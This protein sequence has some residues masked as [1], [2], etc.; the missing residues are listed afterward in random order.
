MV[1]ASASR[2]LRFLPL[3]SALLLTA[4]CQTYSSEAVR[5]RNS[6]LEIIASEID[7]IATELRPHFDGDSK[8][9]H[10]TAYNKTFDDLVAFGPLT[11]EARSLF[12]QGMFKTGD[13]L[14][15][16]DGDYDR[17]IARL[18]ACSS[19]LRISIKQGEAELATAKKLSFGGSS[20]GTPR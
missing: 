7:N 5:L 12:L 19:R 10:E 8:Q 17:W 18:R 9:D 14:N 20:D 2:L 13:G 1:N 16:L 4:G 15:E 3:L 11:P 6:D